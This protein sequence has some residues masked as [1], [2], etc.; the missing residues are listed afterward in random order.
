[1][2]DVTSLTSP[3][4]SNRRRS[5]SRR[6]QNNKAIISR[7]YSSIN[8]LKATVQKGA[9]AYRKSGSRSSKAG[10]RRSAI[11]AAETSKSSM[12]V[13]AKCGR[14]KRVVGQG[15][16]SSM[17][18][19]WKFAGSGKPLGEENVIVMNMRWTESIFSRCTGITLKRRILVNKDHDIFA[20]CLPPQ[21]LTERRTTK[22]SGQSISPA[23]PQM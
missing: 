10:V 1:M 17:G 11:V 14:N 9:R 19:G 15:G 7:V 16:K 18:R 2:W 12:M 3:D 6:N 8:G 5:R 4:L 13:S 20:G 21:R 22:S 23:E